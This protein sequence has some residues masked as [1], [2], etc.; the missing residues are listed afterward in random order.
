M[1]HV[2][3]GSHLNDEQR[4]AVETTRGPVAILAGAGTGKT[5]TV[6]HRIAHQVRSGAFAARNILAVTF[7][8]KAA[9]ELRHRLTLL[10]V[11]VGSAGVQARTFHS[12]ALWHLR[13][14]WHEYAGEPLPSIDPNAIDTILEPFRREHDDLRYVRRRELSQIIGKCRALRISVSDSARDP[15]VTRELGDISA[16]AFQEAYEHYVSEMHRQN[17]WDFADVIEN[18]VA[19]LSDHPEARARIQGRFQAFTV[20]EYQD[21]NE[22]QQ[23]AL[24][25]WLGDRRDLCVVGDD[26]QSIYAFQGGTP[27]Y[28]TGFETRFPEAHVVALTT[29]Y[30]STP[31]VLEVANK[32]SSKLADGRKPRVLGASRS[33]AAPVDTIP[34]DS[35]NDEASKVAQQIRIAIDSGTPPSGFAVLYRNRS[36]SVAFESALNALEVP[37][38]VSGGGILKRTAYRELRAECAR[39]SGNAAGPAVEQVTTRLEADTSRRYSE[40]L[41]QERQQDFQALRDLAQQAGETTLAQFWTDLEQRFAE[42]GSSDQVVLST[43]H[44]SKGLEWPIVF[45]TN[46][47]AETLPH[48]YKDIV[49][50]HQEERRLFY[51]A[52]TRARDRL[53]VSWSGRPSMYVRECGLA[54]EPVVSKSNVGSRRPMSSPVVPNA[55]VVTLE[56]GSRIHHKSFGEGV[57]SSVKGKTAWVK[58]GGSPAAKSITLPSLQ[59]TV[60]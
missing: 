53:V 20:D 16:A 11:D 7:T 58:F 60:L 12:H 45:V 56:P 57:V 54:P 1:T 15:R 49:A 29:N 40:E 26:Y 9:E 6:T 2:I 21:V 41:K 35:S 38:L 19:L 59:V 5:A 14:L 25:Q 18:N 27:L 51:V 36:Q 55:A 43:F 46:A 34:A 33:D 28:L 52:I 42:D 31:Q 23:A 32:L 8:R 30:R 48:R 4:E 10:G 24:D 37:Y 13:T 17:L 47:N 39:D 3:D 22:A 44:G 50:D